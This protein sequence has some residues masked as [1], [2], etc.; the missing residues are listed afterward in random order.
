MFILLNLSFGNCF[1][2]MEED[3]EVKDDY[4]K[5]TEVCAFMLLASINM[6]VFMLLISIILLKSPNCLN[7]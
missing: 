6:F 3:K 4:I 2:L 5:K 1:A 7:I